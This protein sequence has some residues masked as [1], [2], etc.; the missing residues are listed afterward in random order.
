M[1]KLTLVSFLYRGEYR[2]RFVN[3][4]VVNG[5]AVCSQE[6]MQKMIRKE[7]IPMGA[8]ISIA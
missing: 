3:L 6:Y 2:T 7:F 8:T 4:P 1:K 5:H